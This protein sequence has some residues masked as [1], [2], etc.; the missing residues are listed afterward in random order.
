VRGPLR[1]CNTSV[2]IQPKVST[3]PPDRPQISND[4][5]DQLP[6]RQRNKGRS[7]RVGQQ[8]EDVDESWRRMA[9]PDVLLD[10]SDGKMRVELPDSATVG[11]L[12]EDVQ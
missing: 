8:A 5:K 7:L 12:W 1:G 9:V 4:P 10:F 3:L 6:W 2:N 11:T